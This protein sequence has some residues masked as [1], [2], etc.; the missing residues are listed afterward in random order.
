M[1]EATTSC[2]TFPQ[3]TRSR[4]PFGK[5]GHVWVDDIKVCSKELGCG[6][7]EWMQLDHVNMAVKLW[8]PQKESNFLNN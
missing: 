4:G 3:K 5:S 2:K 1:A 8:V 6:S 7:V